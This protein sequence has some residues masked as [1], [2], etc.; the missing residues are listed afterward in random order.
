MWPRFMIEST[1]YIILIDT[2]Y[3][4]NM[5][6]HMQRD[7]TRTTII[8]RNLINGRV[9][10]WMEKNSL[11]MLSSICSWKTRP[12]NCHRVA[13]TTRWG[14]WHCFLGWSPF[15]R[16]ATCQIAALLAALPEHLTRTGGVHG[17]ESVARIKRS[18]T[19]GYRVVQKYIQELLIMYF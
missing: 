11:E 14:R 10:P 3:N 15:Q 9:F 17:M 16:C 5:P 2:M 1:W 6:Y 19:H 18:S 13:C 12:F 8:S 4:I 7:A